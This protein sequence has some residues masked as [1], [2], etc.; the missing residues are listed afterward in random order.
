MSDHSKLLTRLIAQI[1]KAI[2]V[3]ETRLDMTPET[4]K[5]VEIEEAICETKK[6]PAPD[7][8]P[9]EQ[10]Q[11]ELKKSAKS[12]ATEGAADLAKAPAKKGSKP[13][14]PVV[15]TCTGFSFNREDPQPCQNKEKGDPKI[16][17]IM[18]E[19][20]LTYKGDEKL[21]KFKVCQQCKKKYLSDKNKGLFDGFIEKITKTKKNSKK[22]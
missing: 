9:E 21:S 20:H 3:V 18:E 5:E 13:K 12:S 17:H 1:K 16:P 19:I 14:T 2:T 22:E 8:E 4:I 15:F 6:R 11:P 10:P 7:A